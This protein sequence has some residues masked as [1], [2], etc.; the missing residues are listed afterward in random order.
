MMAASGIVYSVWRV[1]GREVA[2]C[3]EQVVCEQGTGKK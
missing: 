2:G 1:W 3:R